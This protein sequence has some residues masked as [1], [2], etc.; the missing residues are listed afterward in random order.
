M[1]RPRPYCSIGRK[2]AETRVW[3]FSLS[4]FMPVSWFRRR[5]E[6]S[7]RR[8]FFRE[9]AAPHLSGFFDGWGVFVVLE[10]LPAYSSHPPKRVLSAC[11]LSA[12][13]GLRRRGR[14]LGSPIDCHTCDETGVQSEFA[15]ASGLR[16][17]FRPPCRDGVVVPLIM[18]YCIIFHNIHE[19]VV[20]GSLSRFFIPRNIDSRK[21]VLHIPAILSVTGNPACYSQHPLPV[22]RT[23]SL[24]IVS[25]RQPL[26]ADA[27]LSG[28]RRLPSLY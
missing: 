25:C 6:R 23:T 5:T 27:G 13:T 2:T 3:L 19:N 21:C 18:L 15:V 14:L 9:K 12:E 24:R 8:V 7:G 10:P 22:L 4:L 1:T 26:K 17:I 11:G 20:S 16:L 28:L